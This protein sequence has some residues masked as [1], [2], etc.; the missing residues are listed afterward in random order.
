MQNLYTSLFTA[1]QIDVL[2]A[3][4]LVG[5][6]IDLHNWVLLHCHTAAELENDDNKFSLSNTMVLMRVHDLCPHEA[7]GPILYCYVKCYQ[8]SFLQATKMATAWNT[9]H[10]DI[11]TVASADTT[12]TTICSYPK[13]NLLWF[14]TSIQEFACPVSTCNHIDSKYTPGTMDEQKHIHTH[15]VEFHTPDQLASIPDTIFSDYKL[16]IF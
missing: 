12:P 8:I 10:I 16:Y 1:S 4:S 7:Y 11:N 9:A 2:Q 3:L 5:S 13:H 15:F 6:H 14:N